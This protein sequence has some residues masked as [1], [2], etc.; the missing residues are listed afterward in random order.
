MT[1]E[2]TAPT[3]CSPVAPPGEVALADAALAA[4]ITRAASAQ[5]YYIIRFLVD[6]DR[7]ADAYRAY[8]YFRWIDDRIDEGE[9]PAAER[10]AFL[11]RQQALVEAGYCAA[12]GGR[13]M[14]GDLCPE[15][16]LLAELI[17]GDREPDSGLRTYLGN[18]MAV[19]AIDTTRRGRLISAA[20]LDRYIDLLATGV[21]E[22][23]MHFIGHNCPAPSGPE[24]SRAV[25]G[26]CVVHMLRD[27][28]EDAA[29]GY[30]NVPAEYLAA[31]GLGPGDV[32]EPAFRDWV[33]GRVALAR[34]CFREGRA[35]IAQVGN[36]R[37]RLA[38]RAYIARFEYVARLIERDNYRL[39]AAYPERK[40]P[41]AALWMAARTISNHEF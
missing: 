10:A 36:A 25:Y 15:E 29:A 2:L 26:A 35:F 31:H 41:R 40:S 5:S 24:R 34:D 3:A 38:G 28:M 7:V 20:E 13:P 27:L 21:M 22:A 16:R 33:A 30:Y 23:L 32:G 1:I 39:R 6:R 11:R 37:C 14:P 17:A 9:E 4:A 12:A 8:A 18:M 19:M